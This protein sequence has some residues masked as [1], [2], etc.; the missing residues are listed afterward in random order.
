MQLGMI[1]L[2]RMGANMVRRLLRGGHQCVVFDVNADNIRQLANEGATG[3]TSLDEFLRAL[4]KPRA[5]WVMVPAGEPT[6][7]T[8]AALSQRMDADD[9]IIDGGNSY[10]KDDVRR[11]KAL[12]AQEIHYV[13]VGTRGGILGLE[14]EQGMK[15][16]ATPEN[17]AGIQAGVFRLEA[18][19]GAVKVKAHVGQKA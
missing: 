3:A 18:M 11:A 13:A 10:Y 16:R 8:I 15:G 6:E 9:I 5:A 19:R 7:Q 1:G 4:T 2:G 12:Q 17:I 14:V